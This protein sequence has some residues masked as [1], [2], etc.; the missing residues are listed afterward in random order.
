MAS[1]T[2]VTVD[3][4]VHDG[5]AG[6]RTATLTWTVRS[7]QRVLA[8][9]KPKQRVSSKVVN[10]ATSQGDRSSTEGAESTPGSSPSHWRFG[11]VPKPTGYDEGSGP[12]LT[13]ECLPPVGDA[14]DVRGFLVAATAPGGAQCEAQCLV[15]DGDRVARMHSVMPKDAFVGLDEVSFQVR[16]EVLEAAASS[17]SAVAA[18][19]ASSVRAS[20]ETATTVVAAAAHAHERPLGSSEAVDALGAAAAATKQQAEE[21]RVW[22]AFFAPFALD[23]AAF[24]P[25]WAHQALVWCQ[26]CGDLGALQ[27]LR[28]DA[29]RPDDVATALGHPIALPKQGSP[30][31]SSLLSRTREALR[32]LSSTRV[33]GDDAWRKLLIIVHACAA[34]GTLG[35]VAAL[36]GGLPCA[37]D[38]NIA[39]VLSVPCAIAAHPAGDVAMPDADMDAQLELLAHLHSAAADPLSFAADAAV[40]DGVLAQWT[41]EAEQEAARI[42][43]VK[44]RRKQ[45]CASPA[46]RRALSEDREDPP[47]PPTLCADARDAIRG[48][49]DALADLCAAVAA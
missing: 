25:N 47:P 21:A 33:P 12:D 41:V 4:C 48:A 32:G 35:D 10:V 11:L 23:G 7:L 45:L 9:A 3:S 42:S 13:I 31:C 22:D 16:L 30:S 43:A 15:A 49:R 18:R 20:A 37:D 40:L 38:D 2:S 26:L 5:S 24:P 44:Q 28:D 1:V 8:A 29:A 17:I 36:L 39:A 34:A 14:P 6:T 27:C 19:F 46:H